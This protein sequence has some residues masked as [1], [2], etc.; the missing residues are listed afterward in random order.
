MF[1]S[2]KQSSDGSAA[3]GLFGRLGK[4]LK[5]R[6]TPDLAELFRRH[7]VVDENILEEIETLLLAGDVGVKAT[8]RIVSDLTARLKRKQLA[9]AEAV[10]AALRSDMVQILEPV[11]QPL[12]IPDG[13]SKPFVILMVGV[14]GTGKTTTIAKLAKRFQEQ[15][16]RVMLAAGDTFRAAAVEQLQAWGQRLGIPV[17]AQQTGADAASVIYDALASAR[18]RGADVLVADTAGRLHTQHNLMDE[19]RK[20]RRVIQKFDGQAPHETLLVLDAGTGQNALTQSERFHEAVQVSGLV[21]TKLDGTAR[22]GMVFAV[23]EKL[24]LPIRFIGIGEGLDDLQEFDAE[25]FVDALLR[26]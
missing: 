23:A 20:V 18:A 25:E 22:G 9:D 17:V 3:R 26:S 13:A 12:R 2:R 6:F 1:P 8:E 19:L 5:A 15:G 10:M 11:S 16:R 7:K 24:G 14:N 21:L 4:A